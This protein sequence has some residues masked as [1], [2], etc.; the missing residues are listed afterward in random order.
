M[1]ITIIIGGLP[2]CITTGDVAF[3][4][5]LRRQYAG[6]LALPEGVQADPALTPVELE[7]E[8]AT[9]SRIADDEDLQVRFEAGAW[10][11]QRGDFHA[12]YYPALRRGTVRQSANRH[13][14]DSVIRIIHSLELAGTGGFLL[15][16]ASAVRA[17]K[18]FVFSGLSG[19]GKTTMARLAPADVDLLTDEVSYIR[20]LGEGFSAWGTPFAGELAQPGSNLV[21]PLGAL[22]FL[23]QARENRITPMP[24]GEALRLLMRNVLFFADDSQLVAR[25]FETAYRFI[26]SAEVYR[27]AFMPDTRVWNLI[28]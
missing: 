10:T 9:P 11:L 6:F 14:I 28:R 21:R 22:Y 17:D 8:L 24:L 2:V 12:R 13:S 18:A 23:E 25:V 3:H 20:P 15:H 19:A 1:N 7:I 26:S 4:H 16:A 27:L 5:L